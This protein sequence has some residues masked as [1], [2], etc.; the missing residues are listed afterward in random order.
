M[1]TRLVQAGGSAYI[2]G[3]A[4]RDA[5]RVVQHW[6]ERDCAS[7]IGY[8]N[9]D[10][11]P[12][13]RLRDIGIESVRLVA[14][15]QLAA[16]ISIKTPALHHDLALLTSIARA[17]AACAVPLHLDAHSLDDH[18]PTL[19]ALRE[20]GQ[21]GATVGF[22]LPARWHRSVEDAYAL[23]DRNVRLR[24]VK[25][26]W[27]D[28]I[29]GDL[30]PTDGFIGLIRILAGRSAPVAVATHDP[31]LARIALEHLRHAHTPC[32]LELLHGLPQRAVSHVARAMGVPVRIY[33]PFGTAWLPYALKQVLRRPRTIVWL[34]HDTVVAPLRRRHYKDQP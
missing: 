20:M 29:H 27:A 17:A 25:G 7:T 3:P 5:R 15:E 24:I 21:M 13:Q 31:V 18:P 6:R 26:Q 34:I 9:H 4:L 22:T 32:E 2:A 30:D 11:E 28:T 12:P 1:A 10:D 19:E 33:V 23:R 14:L 16:Y 8:F